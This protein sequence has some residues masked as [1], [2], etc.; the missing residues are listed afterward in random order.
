MPNFSCT[1]HGAT[2]RTLKSSIVD[3][4]EIGSY[5]SF[6]AAMRGYIALSRVTAAHKLLLS[7]PFSPL[8]FQQG[9]QPFPSLLMDVLLGKVAYEDVAE[10]CRQTRQRSKDIRLL[11]HQKWS[12]WMCKN[13]LMCDEYVSAADD[14]WYN[15]VFTKI[16]KRR[17]SLS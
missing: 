2:G 8:L 13:D 9:Q 7:Q 1:I 4:G 6:Q 11:K 3:L 14:N 15:E 10:K 17:P 12:C 16:V 5:P